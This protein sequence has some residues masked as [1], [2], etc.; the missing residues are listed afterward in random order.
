MKVV[1]IAVC[2]LLLLPFTAGA[3]FVKETPSTESVEPDLVDIII[4]ADTTSPSFYKGR[5]EPSAGSTIR[6]IAVLQNAQQEDS[7]AY[8]WEVENDV[9]G[10]GAV[11]GQ[12][13][14]V[15]TAPQ[16][17]QFR[18]RVDVIDLAGKAIAS[19]QR[20]IT[21]S[22]PMVAFYEDSPLR[23]V[24]GI[25]IPDNYV[26]VSEEVSVR[27]EPYFVSQDIFLND[28]DLSWHIDGR[29]VSNPTANPQVITLRNN[30]GSG[31]FTI[32]FVLHNLLSLTQ[33]VR[34]A[35]TITF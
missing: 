35:F 20:F 5:R 13:V 3:Q 14:I 29:E 6:A 8:R 30:G 19:E 10:G 24:S 27:A 11:L 2:C 15:F 21:L 34:N 1:T 32:D 22:E 23:G 16:T 28:Y 17:D 18:I 9:I 4:E 26:L 31:T 12:D 25:A 7:Y 33:S